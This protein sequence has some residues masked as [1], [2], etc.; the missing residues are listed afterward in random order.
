MLLGIQLFLE[1]DSQIL[2]VRDFTGQGQQFFPLLLENHDTS[3]NI[4]FNGNQIGQS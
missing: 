2:V 1:T 4:R 3:K